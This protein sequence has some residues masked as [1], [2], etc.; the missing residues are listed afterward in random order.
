M[1]NRF[2][3]C[4]HT[5][6]HNDTAAS[7]RSRRTESVRGCFIMHTEGSSLLRHLKSSQMHSDCKRESC[8]AHAFVC[9]H[10]TCAGEALPP[11]R[12][13]DPTH[14]E[15]V[16]WGRELYSSLQKDSKKE[17][18]PLYYKDMAC[19][20]SVPPAPSP[21]VNI[22]NMSP[23]TPA[24]LVAVQP[25]PASHHH[26]RP[27]F[28]NSQ[29]IHPHITS[30]PANCFSAVIVEDVSRKHTR[31]NPQTNTEWAHTPM[32]TK[33]ASM[34]LNACPYNVVW[35]NEAKNE[36]GNFGYYIPEY[37]RLIG[38]FGSTIF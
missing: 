2:Q 27:T 11:R 28:M 24:M 29:R 4:G 3:Y 5:C 26:S 21:G 12:S 35:D 8:P 23:P 9:E 1:V 15:W 19:G 32:P 20:G 37:V 10:C 38:F 34:M 17:D 36:D 31:D 25:M 7:S 30:D 14:E 16:T 18:W 22:W 13:R 33:L 6:T